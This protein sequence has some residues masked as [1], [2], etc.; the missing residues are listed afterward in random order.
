MTQYKYTYEGQD[1]M[2]EWALRR[3]MPY[4]SMPK[5]LTDEIL[6]QYGIVKSVIPS[7]LETLDGARRVA[8]NQLEQSFNQYSDS[9]N[10]YITS[11]LGFKANCRYRAFMDVSGLV[12]QAK[13]ADAKA[14]E[15]AEPATVTFMDFDDTPHELTAEQLETLV[16][17]ISQNGTR[18]YGVKWVY[19]SALEAAES[20]EEIKQIAAGGFDFQHGDPEE[21]TAKIASIKS[22][23]AAK[24]E[25]EAQS[26]TAQA[27]T[28]A[29]AQTTTTKARRKKSA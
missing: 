25:A 18:A 23:L 16:L 26:E 24:A 27:E 9:K 15:G 13:D 20:V 22:E 1:Y 11:S 10:S 14:E 4:V 12:L 6:E 19:R 7:T 29:A 17:E 3:A 8:L 28:Q 2:S 21:L 5:V